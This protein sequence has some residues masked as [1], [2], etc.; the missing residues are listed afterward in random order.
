MYIGDLS[1]PFDTEKYSVGS[2]LGRYERRK[3]VLPAFQRSYSWEKA[4]VVTFWDD[5]S[6]F[7]R[8]YAKS[9]STASYFLGSVVVIEREDS[10]LLL[11]GQQR[12][13]TATIALAAMRDLGR[14]LDK[15]KASKGADLARDIQ[16]ELIEKD[17][18]PVTHSLTLGELD[19]PFFA[20]AIKSD[21]P[22]VP[23][24]R[25]RSHGL[26]QSAYT[27][28]SER[29]ESGV[30]AK[31]LEDAIHYLKALRDALTK[32]L[33]II[34]IVVQNEDDAYTIFETLNDRG[35]RLS[36]PDLVLN[37]LMR[38]AGTASSRKLVRTHWNAMLRELGKRDVSRFL[39][40]LWVSRFGDLKNEGLY[41]AI[42][43]E[44][45]EAKLDSATFAEQCAD[46]CADYVALLDIN[47][48]LPTRHGISNLE[49]IVKY[50]QISSAPPLLLSGYRFLSPQD[51][52]KLLKA[53]V[54]THIRYAVVTNQN[55]LDVESRMYEAA[56]TIRQLTDAGRNSAQI[57]S[58][59]KAK[60]RELS[61]LDKVI[62]TAYADLTLE[63]GEAQWIMVQIANSV[64]SSTK[65]IGMDRAN[66]EHIFPQNAKPNEWPN[67]LALEPLIWHVGNMTILG[68]KL[69][70][71]AQNKGFANKCA[72]YYSKSEIKMNKDIAAAQ[73]WDENAIMHRALRLTKCLAQVFPALS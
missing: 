69:N 55:P 22:A 34:G 58:G 66:L 4:Q 18:D 27:Q 49:G 46:E 16:R 28:F 9:P 2:L 17:T 51:F 26:I 43:R 37:L 19:E 72:L 23:V 44:L 30:Q 12:M 70:R 21:P 42:R 33:T 68:E 31:S 3:I 11:D 13:A 24:S 32:G 64:Q 50:L 53:I 36:V 65:E 63:R 7:A 41:A 67:A 62:E 39:R 15:G 25:L 45:D 10:L 54:G 29:L 40:H 73:T 14:R 38:R 56:R 59:A 61:V 47:V 1:K 60:L 8:E 52:E 5:L 48:P 6:R 35:L 71:Q 57:L 20:K